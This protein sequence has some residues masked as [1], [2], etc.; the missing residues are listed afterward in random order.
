VRPHLN[1]NGS[2]VRTGPRAP[3][4]GGADGRDAATGP[5]TSRR[6]R[7][8]LPVAAYERRHGAAACAHRI[9]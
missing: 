2:V 7:E 6:F 3:M 1:L 8:I 9:T 5:C 4:A